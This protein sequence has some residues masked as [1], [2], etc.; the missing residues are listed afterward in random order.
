MS[1]IKFKPIL[2]TNF[3]IGFKTASIVFAYVVMIFKIYPLRASL[4]YRYKQKNYPTRQ[5]RNLELIDTVMTNILLFGDKPHTASSNTLISNSTINYVIS[6]MFLSAGSGTVDFDEFTEAF[7][8]AMAPPNSDELRRTFKSMD[9]NGDGTLS[10]EE[11][12]DALKSVGQ[13]LSNEGLCDLF[14]SLDT[15]KNGAIDFE[16]K[17][18]FISYNFYLI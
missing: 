11:L 10:L 5:H 15:N 4:S 3:N 1:G 14:E 17:I 13:P 8:K 2:H 18:R 12:Q 7:L 16:G 6:L 9:T